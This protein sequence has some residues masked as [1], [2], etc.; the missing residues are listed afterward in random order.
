V[1]DV[2]EGQHSFDGLRV[3]VLDVTRAHGRFDGKAKILIERHSHNALA[4]VQASIDYAKMF[5]PSRGEVLY[6]FVTEP[7]EDERELQWF[8][9]WMHKGDLRKVQSHG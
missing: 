3:R 9:N 2:Y 7:R 1:G 4:S 8:V 5:S 6:R